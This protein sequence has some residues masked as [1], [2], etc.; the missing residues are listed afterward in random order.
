[1][2]KTLILGNFKGKKRGRQQSMRWL[3]STSE[4]MNMNLS[5]PQ[6]IVKD[7]G[8]LRCAAVHRFAES[9]RLHN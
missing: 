2:E 6:E 9:D 8:V 4:A 3:D 7:R 1:M 5:K